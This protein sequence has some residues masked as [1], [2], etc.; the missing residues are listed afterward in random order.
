MESFQQIPTSVKNVQSFSIPKQAW[1]TMS[2]P[3]MV[4]KLI[5]TPDNAQINV[6]TL[7]TKSQQEKTV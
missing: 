3:S 2:I 5:S 1:I 6:S 7:S 4:Q